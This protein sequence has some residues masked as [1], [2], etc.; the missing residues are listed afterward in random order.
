MTKNGVKEQ[1]GQKCHVKANRIKKAGVITRLSLHVQNNGKIKYQAD[2]IT[3]WPEVFISPG[4]TLKVVTFTCI[5]SL[6]TG[7]TDPCFFLLLLILKESAVF[8]QVKRP[9]FANHFETRVIMKDKKKRLSLGQCEAT[10][11][12]KLLCQ[13]HRS[14]NR[15]KT[16]C[17]NIHHR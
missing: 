10:A 9:Q 5:S 4:L 6:K 12:F 1:H 7:R 14:L 2:V 16:D 8:S 15:K 13:G 11:L 17:G 3:P